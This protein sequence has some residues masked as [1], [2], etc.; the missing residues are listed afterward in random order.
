MVGPL[1]GL[2]FFKK[3]KT[4]KADERGMRACAVGLLGTD[5]A[6]LLQ[7]ARFLEEQ[8]LAVLRADG[9]ADTDYAPMAAYFDAR[10]AEAAA[11]PRS[12]ILPDAGAFTS[13]SDVRLYRTVTAPRSSSDNIDPPAVTVFSQPFFFPFHIIMKSFDQSFPQTTGLVGA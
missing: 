6:T 13:G 9:A 1:F 11:P 8:A 2:S 3:R 10:A 5:F 12:A 4:E 7:H